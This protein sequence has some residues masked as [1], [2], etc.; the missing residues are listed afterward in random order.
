MAKYVVIEGKPYMQLDI[1]DCEILLEA[2][3]PLKFRLDKVVSL[4]RILLSE[5]DISEKRK[6][7]F[8]KGEKKLNA[9]NI[10]YDIIVS[11]GNHTN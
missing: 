11:I 5:N 3:Q 4:D 6:R 1:E 9:I 7:N 2:L 8:F 10:M